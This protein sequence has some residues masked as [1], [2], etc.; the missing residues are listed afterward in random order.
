MGGIGISLGYQKTKEYLQKESL[1]NLKS[2]FFPKPVDQLED[3][4]YKEKFIQNTII[5]LK[6]SI[7]ILEKF[8]DEK[9]YLLAFEMY[10][11]VWGNAL[12]NFYNPNK[13]K[14]PDGFYISQR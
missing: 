13:I 14:P 9:R 7:K 5:S 1:I 4:D 6:D 11:I 2:E 3:I 8:D 10:L 12:Y